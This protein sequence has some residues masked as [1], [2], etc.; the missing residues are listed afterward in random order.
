MML[1]GNPA[2]PV[3]ECTLFN[4]NAQMAPSLSDKLDFGTHIW[5]VEGLSVQTTGFYFFVAS[6]CRQ[7]ST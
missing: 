4:F 7:R 3:A 2:L 5:L 1:L 6:G